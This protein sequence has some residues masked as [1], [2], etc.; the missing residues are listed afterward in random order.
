M[1][2]AALLAAALLLAIACSGDGKLPGADLGRT[3]AP[4]FTLRA[5]DGSAVRLSDYRGRTVLLTFLYTRCPDICPAIAGKL[6]DTARRLGSSAGKVQFLAVSVDPEGDTPA[7]VAQFTADHG[8]TALGPRWLYGLGSRAELA[9]V[10]HDYGIGAE[11]QPAALSALRPDPA[12]PPI[13]DHNA[14]LYL[15]DSAGRERTLLHPDITSQDLAGALKRL[16]GG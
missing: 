4:D 9:A 12:A 14:V 3:P 5:E 13:I 6:A 10:W 2:S 15:I 1:W 7:S 8:L 11:P 16:A